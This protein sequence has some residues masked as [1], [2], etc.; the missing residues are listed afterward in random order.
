MARLPLSLIF[1][2]RELPSS[3]LVAFYLESTASAPCIEAAK[4]TKPI[5]HVSR[6]TL[7]STESIFKLHEVLAWQMLPRS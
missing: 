3:G 4:H 2:A 1:V 6:I 5:Q 7:T